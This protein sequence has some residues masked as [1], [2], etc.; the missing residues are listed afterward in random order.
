M[1][2]SVPKGL[3]YYDSAVS[4]GLTQDIEEWFADDDTQAGL[5]PVSNAQGKSSINSRRVLHFGWKY[6]YSTG[7][8]HE[9][10]PDL[11][12]ILFVLRKQIERVWVDAP[13]EFSVKSLDQCIVNQYQPGQGIGA[14]IDSN[15]YGDFIVCFTFGNGREMEFTRGDEKYMMYTTPRSM[16]VMSGESRSEWKHQMRPRKVDTVNGKRVPREESFSVT[17][18]GI[19]R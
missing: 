6:N 15:S 11:P 17:F 13:P 8:V 1:D 9:R 2:D 18:R 4:P 19:R 5:F 14:H 7:G 16:Y 10:A 3:F 12:F